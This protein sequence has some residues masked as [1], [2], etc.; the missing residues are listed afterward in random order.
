MNKIKRYAPFGEREPEPGVID[1][2]IPNPFEV[3]NG[4][5]YKKVALGKLQVIKN[6]D[7]KA[8]VESG[9]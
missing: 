5:F 8:Y 2:I 9:V 6:E 1:P 4:D 7:Y 3:A